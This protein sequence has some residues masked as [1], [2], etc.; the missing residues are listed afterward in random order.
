MLKKKNKNPT[1]INDTFGQEEREKLKVTPYGKILWGIQKER[2]PGWDL[3]LCALTNSSE[4]APAVSPNVSY[5][6]KEMTFH[7]T[8]LLPNI[9]SEQT[10]P[11]FTKSL[12]GGVCHKNDPSN[13][14]KHQYRK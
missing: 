9:G 8:T 5:L 11:S 4:H 14:Y 10:L 7:E 3:Y 2:S 6:Y 12:V 13:K 1:V